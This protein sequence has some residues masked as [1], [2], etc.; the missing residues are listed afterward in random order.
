MAFED[1]FYY[2]LENKL[3]K[4]DLILAISGSG[5]SHNV[6]K[7]VEYAKKVGCQII[8]MSLAPSLNQIVV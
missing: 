3:D 2:Q 8:G 5:N 4:G 1:V 6:V 7:A